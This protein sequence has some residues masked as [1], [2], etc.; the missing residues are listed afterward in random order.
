MP[1]P[2][3]IRASRRLSRSVERLRFGAPVGTVYNPLAYARIPAE[4]Y[5]ERFAA[6]SCRMVFLGMNPGPWGM[7]Q[8]GVPFGEIT[9]ARDWLGIHGAVGVPHRVHPRVPVTG[10]ACTRS[11]V[12]GRRLWGLLRETYGTA[13][14]FARDACVANYCPLLFLDTEG[15]NLTPDRLSRADRDALFPA[16]DEYLA[17]LLDLLKPQ[18]VVGVGAFAAARLRAVNDD[19]PGGAVITLPHPS[20]ANPAANRGWANAARSVLVDAGA[21]P[22]QGGVVTPLPPRRG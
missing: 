22:R 12:S 20:P 19:G 10:F 9:A 14:A 11:E 3:A 13:E 5:L 16:C 1:L 21:W 17:T 7:A 6:S 2:A 15:R 18:W 8:T 4:A